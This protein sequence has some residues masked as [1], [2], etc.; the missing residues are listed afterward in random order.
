MNSKDTIIFKP[1]YGHSHLY[2]CDELPNFYIAKFPDRYPAWI[3]TNGTNPKDYA[4]L[5]LSR[6]LFEFETQELEELQ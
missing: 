2:S 5:E 4:I 3:H 6:Q 1:V